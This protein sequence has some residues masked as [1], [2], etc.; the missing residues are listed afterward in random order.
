MTTAITGSS[1]SCPRAST[2]DAAATRPAPATTARPAAASSA[3]SSVVTKG[4]AATN[5]APSVSTAPTSRHGAAKAGSRSVG[6]QAAAEAATAPAAKRTRSTV[7]AL[8]AS[9]V[10]CHT[11]HDAERDQ[12]DHERAGAAHGVRVDEGA[13][14][15]PGQQLGFVRRHLQALG[16]LHDQGAEGERGEDAHRSRRPATGC[17]RR[18]RGG[19][20]APRRRPG[21]PARRRPPRANRVSG[22]SWSRL[23]ATSQRMPMPTK[24][25]PRV[26]RRR[27]RSKRR[28]R[29]VARQDRGRGPVVDEQTN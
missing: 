20:P 24:A 25:A 1:R 5:S 27:E 4:S 11:S 28:R 12:A 26:S 16:R 3:K 10:V 21:R 17:R 19:R 7:S 2:A 23:L 8:G 6:A 13:E 15:P 29:V 18:A 14:A 22:G 9:H